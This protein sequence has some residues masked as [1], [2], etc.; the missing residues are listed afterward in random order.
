M[1][2]VV[3]DEPALADDV[4]R[5]LEA[6][7]YPVRTFPDATAALAALSEAVPDLVVSDIRMP[8]MDGFAF[9]REV[10]RRL[11]GRALPFLFLSSLDDPGNIVRGLDQGADDY[12]VKPAHPEVLAARVRAALAR[13]RRVLQPAFDGD[14]ARLPL[15]KVMQFCEQRRL[16]GSV[17][18]TAD[19]RSATV[20]YQG[21]EI[22]ED[23]A[24]L[25]LLE[26]VPEIT[27]GRFR[28]SVDPVDY[29]AIAHAAA[30]AAA[31]AA[32]P[33]EE[34]VM[35]QLSGVRL[36]PRLFQIQTEHVLVPDAQVVTVVI[37]D[38]RTVMK[39]A[40]PAAGLGR[41]SVA[42]AVRDQHA[43]VE[44]EVNE[45]LA[46]GTSKAE[47]GGE[48]PRER[49]NRLFEAGFDRYHAGALAEAIALWEQ[50]QAVDP[51]NKTLDVNLR[52]ARQKLARAA[53]RG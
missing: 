16:T 27:G 8:G 47:P 43:R 24:A 18:V 3:D 17:E 39:R 25:D 51:E 13:A 46:R 11:G 34:R 38:G 15:M 20:R 22:V 36:G 44:G 45:R 4:R 10:R 5:A 32:T 52:I 12:L 42:Q 2:F 31:P 6:K 23:D 40:T 49:F 14:L 26:R 30:E 1:I 9:Q 41:E 33:P 28:I 50:A 21:G 19:G 35:G 48:S 53:P 37:L 29:G 7:G